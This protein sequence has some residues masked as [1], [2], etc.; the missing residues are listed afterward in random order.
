[1]RTVFR[2]AEAIEEFGHPVVRSRVHRG[3]WQRPER[4]VLVTHNGPLSD[5]ERHEVG[6]SLC[7]RA[8]AFAGL[9]ALELDGLRGFERRET[10]VVLSVRKIREALTRRGPCRRRALIVESILDAAGGIQSI[11]ER[12]FDE[13]RRC[14][15]LPKP[16]RQVKVKGKDGRYYLDV[17]W[18]ELGIAVEIHGIPHLEVKNWDADLVRS[19][20]IVIGGRR[21]V[22][23]TSYAI[24]HEPE[25][26]ADQ[27]KRLFQSA[28][29]A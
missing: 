7:P 4:G 17:A 8:S 28:R 13:I 11:P 14:C 24:R 12:D 9:S 21:L 29:S 27:L 19:N 26:V 20:E 15:G 2:L 6:L 5:P 23:F 22:S 3:L 10:Y 16:S 25:V 1:M 18:I